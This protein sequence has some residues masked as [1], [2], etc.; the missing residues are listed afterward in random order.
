[1]NASARARLSFGVFL[2]AL[3]TLMVELLL[4]RVFDVVLVSNLGYM[5]ISC[6]LFAFGL[7][8]VYGALRPLTDLTKTDGYLARLGLALAASC[9]LQLPLLNA[10]PFDLRLVVERPVIETFYFLL[11]YLTVTLPF[12][13][14]GLILATAFSVYATQIR[15]LYFFDLVGAALGAVIVVPLIRPLG[16]GGLMFVAAALALIAAA[17]FRGRSLHLALAAG[18]AAVLIAV[19]LLRGDGYYDFRPHLDK[20]GVLE[21]LDS[22]EIELTLWDPVSKIDVIP[23][24]A[25]DDGGPE[26]APAKFVRYDGGSQSTHLFAFDGDFA[27]LRRELDR[28]IDNAARYF[29]NRA[30]PLSHWFKADTDADVLIIGSA[31]GQET[32]AALTYGAGQVDAIEM[33]AA[34]VEVATDT[35]ADY[36]GDLF[37]DPRVDVRVGEGRTF[38]RGTNKTYDIIQIFSNHTSSSIAAGNGAAATTYLQT[39]DAYVEYF[40]HL[41][42][43]GILQVNHHIYP[44]M[45]TTAALAW[46]WLGRQDFRK[47]VVVYER[48]TD[49]PLPT[50]LIKMTPWTQE[51]LARLDGYMLA[52]NP[53][54]EYRLMENPLDP[55]QSFLTNDFYDRPDAP[56]LMDLVDYVVRPATDDRPYFNFIRRKL[57]SLDPDASRF[58]DGGTAYVLNSQMRAGAPLD[59]IHFVV[60]GAAALMFALVFVFVPL[61]ASPAGRSRWP[62]K[63]TSIFYFS[64][65]GAGFIIIEL[66]LIQIFMKL[67]GF[68][69][70]AYSVVIFTMLLAAG[71]GSLSADRF[72]ISPKRHWALPFI[73]VLLCGGVLWLIYTPVFGLFLAAPLA[74]R[75]LVG[76]AMI[77]P[78]GFFMGMPLPL[79]ILALADRPRGAVAW[80]WA[81]NGLFTVI[82]GLIAAIGS[83]YLGFKVLLLIGF[84]IYVAA[85]IAFLRLHLNLAASAL[86]D[87]QSSLGSVK[88]A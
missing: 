69:L 71:L 76:A 85:G 78:M 39:A 79:G 19:P 66:T 67:I 41:K 37:L 24:A 48:E 47:H 23:V 18:A 35:Y 40:T 32:K 44:R 3:V 30:V 11:I 57:A 53:D 56:E 6:A 13:F 42:D 83:I 55:E 68:P 65:L 54:N 1:M 86:R 25:D 9:V 5:I 50:M 17:L 36:I 16:P 15:K 29:W 82:G 73:G 51:E 28:D 31:G 59:L 20:R 34:V 7:A 60:T 43:D 27:A 8:G 22:G 74:V 72:D 26:Q 84:A 64:C 2:V 61:L 58:L 46:Q 80:A 45:I 12:F 14:A 62:D 81:M 38:L 33:V 4:I 75:I 49:D 77:F 52:P 70:Y 88:P 63:L 21:A 10:N 87:E